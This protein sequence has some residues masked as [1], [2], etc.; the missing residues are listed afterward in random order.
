[1][2][3]FNNNQPSL[4]SANR[5]TRQMGQTAKHTNATS[6]LDIGE[7]SLADVN[8]LRSKEM[9]SLGPINIVTA[10]NPRA[11]QITTQPAKYIKPPYEH[12]K[13]PAKV[14]DLNTVTLFP[15]NVNRK[16]NKNDFYRFL[17]Q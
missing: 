7:G 13:Q 14:I 8:M 10:P 11:S 1:V 3:F 16:K 4:G 12:V 2:E 6:R 5:Q 15:S 9:E 17:L